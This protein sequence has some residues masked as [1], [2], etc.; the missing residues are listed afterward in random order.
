MDPELHPDGSRL[1]VEGQDLFD[2]SGNIL[3]GAEEIDDVDRLVDIGET[4]VTWLVQ[5]D[6]ELRIDRDDTV[7]GA[8]HVLGYPE[9]ILSGLILDP[10]DRDRSRGLEKPDDQLAD[11]LL[12]VHRNPRRA[13]SLRPSPLIDAV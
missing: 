5:H 10:D 3:R 4:R 1:R 6:V 11:V 7:A 12:A 8:L 2:V 9:G 13:T